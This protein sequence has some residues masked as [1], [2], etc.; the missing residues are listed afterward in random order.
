MFH[1]WVLQA[2]VQL[3]IFCNQAYNE[4]ITL[5]PEEIEKLPVVQADINLI[6]RR[7]TSSAKFTEQTVYCQN[8]GIYSRFAIL[9]NV[10]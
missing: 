4:T 10:K 3:Q 9:P 5:Q 8:H 6:T 1:I 7:H 2:G